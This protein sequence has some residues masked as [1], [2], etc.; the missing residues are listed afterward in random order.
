MHS[1]VG[2]APAISPG[3]KGARPLHRAGEAARDPSQRLEGLVHPSERLEQQRDL[4]REAGIVRQRL[5]LERPR[6]VR[7]RVLEQRVADLV[8]VPPHADVAV[9]TSRDD[10]L[11]PLPHRRDLPPMSTRQLP[12]RSTIVRSAR[13]PVH[14]Q[15]PVVQPAQNLVLLPGD[16]HRRDGLLEFGRQQMAVVAQVPQ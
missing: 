8:V 16:A 2:S 10:V 5:E 11:R 12:D 7:Q 4:E 9:L 3:R 6:H 13:Q 14:L 1:A 15:T